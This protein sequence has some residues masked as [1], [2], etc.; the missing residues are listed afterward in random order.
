MACLFRVAFAQ[1]VTLRNRWF[2]LSLR[3][4]FKL[5]GFA[6]RIAKPRTPQTVALASNAPR[7]RVANQ[8]TIIVAKSET[9]QPGL[10]S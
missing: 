1:T 5:R 9:Q 8:A 2:T 10:V 3:M 4:C 6:H 7:A